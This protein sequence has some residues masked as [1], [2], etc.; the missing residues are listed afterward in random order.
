M[1]NKGQEIVDKTAQALQQLTDL[2]NDTNAFQEQY[3]SEAAKKGQTY[4]AELK[5][6]D[7]DRRNL[8]SRIDRF[9]SVV[10]NS[11]FLPPAA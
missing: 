1:A 11:V 5:Q 7:D 2:K 4:N 10:S 3:A 8:Q 6:M 9:L